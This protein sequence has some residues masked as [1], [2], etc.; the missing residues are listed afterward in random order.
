MNRFDA[1]QAFVRVA[2]LH[3]F[4]A[5]AEAL[6][7]PKST[8]SSSVMQ[9]EGHLG[10]RLFERTTRRVN[11]TAEGQA[12]YD[13]ARDLLA[14]IDDIETMFRPTQGGLSGR[15][16]VDLPVH[17]ARNLIIP[18]LPQF[19]APHPGLEVEVSC[20]DRPVDVIAEGFDCVIRVGEGDNDGLT[21]RSL[22]E[23]PMANIAS[24][25]YVQH[26]GTPQ[27]LGDLERHRLVHMVGRLG[28]KPDGFEY[29]DGQA[30]RRQAMVGQVYVDS[31]LA[32]HS[33]VV[34]GLGIIQTPR[35]SL[36]DHV[37][38]G[39][40]VEVLPELTARPLPVAIVAPLRR[41][42][43]RRVAA[44]MD[45]AAGLLANYMAPGAPAA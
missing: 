28:A 26:F 13:R 20:A 7:L 36:L 14:D 24:P 19:L 2:E 42:P 29:F 8:V 18:R 3:S 31:T 10:V 40:L 4:T 22:G 6:G 25:A 45:W 27:D 37:K 23:L 39:A 9:L 12:L 34:A 11:L 21:V 44:F 33:A 1:M 16:R 41:Q 15:L 43:A 17:M 5:A 32:H 38:A 35:L 30:W